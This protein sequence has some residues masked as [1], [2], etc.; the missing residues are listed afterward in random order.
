M[1]STTAKDLLAQ[2]D[3]LMRQRIPEELPV[4]T[5][6]VIDEIEPTGLTNGMDDATASRLRPAR[7]VPPQQPLLA[8]KSTSAKPTD[9]RNAFAAGAGVSTASVPTIESNAVDLRDQLNAQLLTKLDGLQHDV[10]SQV[11]QQLEIYASGSLKDHVRDTL[12]PVLT[13]I[14]RD[15]AQQ[16]AED[17]SNRVR[18]VVSKAVD[19]EFAR[20]REQLSKQKPTDPRH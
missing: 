16:V 20:L 7:A 19:S 6:L 14:V 17:T 8:P 13:D 15:I 4:L 2:A 5:D 3:R 9:M 12:L 10:Y 1:S 18:E 11:M